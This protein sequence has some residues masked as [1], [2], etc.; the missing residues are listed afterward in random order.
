MKTVVQNEMRCAVD[1][2]SENEAFCRAMVASFL[3]S[4][5]PT[6]AELADIRCAISEAV[7]NCIVHAYKEKG[8]V[9]YI[10]VKIFDGRIV[11]VQVRDR[12]CGIADVIQA[13]EPLFTTA[14]EGERSGM[15]FSVM[16][17]FMDKLKV[18][19]HVARGTSIVMEKHLS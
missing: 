19:S 1:A 16:E 4:V 5:N 8:G 13:R 15:G 18:V 7:T 6:V 2:K 17:N 14:S 11:R 3:S 9:I 12:G 10:S